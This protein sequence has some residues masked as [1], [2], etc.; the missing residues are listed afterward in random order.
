MFTVGLSERSQYDL[1]STDGM[2]SI[3]LSAG[4]QSCLEGM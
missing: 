3:L 2:H 4:D 1:A